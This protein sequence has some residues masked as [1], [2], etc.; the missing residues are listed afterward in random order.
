[1]QVRIS[2]ELHYVI[3]GEAA[4]IRK[5][6]KTL[7]EDAIFDFLGLDTTLLGIEKKEILKR[8]NINADGRS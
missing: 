5:S 6:I 4:R 1:M 8:R 7:V 2:S 3:K